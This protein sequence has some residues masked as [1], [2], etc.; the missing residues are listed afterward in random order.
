MESRDLRIK[1]TFQ[2]KSVRRSL[3]S[4]CS[5]GMTSYERKNTRQDE[6]AGIA[7]YF[8]FLDL[9]TLR[10]I[11]MPKIIMAWEMP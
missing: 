10:H 3:D 6:P 2:A 8:S 11:A 1:I 4:L 9:F 7:I 5:L